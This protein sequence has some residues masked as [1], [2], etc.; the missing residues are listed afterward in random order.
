MNAFKQL[1]ETPIPE[2]NTNAILFEHNVTKAQALILK[3]DEENKL[4]SANFKTLPH[5]DTGVAHILEHCVLA[6]SKNYPVK[7]PFV[8]LLKTSLKTFLNAMTFP[9]KTLYPVSSKNTQDFYNLMDVYLDAVFNPLLNENTFK[10]EGWHY[11][12]SNKEDPIIY[13]GV[14]FNEMKG[15]QSNPNSIIEHSITKTLYPDTIYKHDS[16]GD[17]Q[18]IPQLTY[19]EF[20]DFHKTYYHP[21]NAKFVITGNI[22]VEEC[23]EKI[24]SYIKGYE[25]S[26]ITAEIETQQAFETPKEYTT[27]YGVSETDKD[28]AIAVVGWAM[29]VDISAIDYFGLQILSA[30]LLDSEAA[31]IKKA[32][33]ESNLGESVIVTGIDFELKQA[34]F[35]TGLKGIQAENIPEVRKIIIACLEKLSTKLDKDLILAA[36]NKVEF[37]HRE[38]PTSGYPRA[39]E[40]LRTILEIWLYEDAPLKGLLFEQPLNEIRSKIENNEPY[41]EELITKYFVNNNHRAYVSI[42]PNVNRAKERLEKETNVLK[43]VKNEMSEEQLT[44]LVKETGQFIEWQNTPDTPEDEAKIPQLSAKDLSNTL[45]EVKQKI[46]QLNNV[47]I[48]QNKVNTNGITYIDIAY[49]IEVLTEEELKNVGIIAAV[50]PKLGTTTYNFEQLALEIDKYTGGIYTSLITEQNVITNELI[51]KFV[52]SVKCLEANQNKALELVKDILMNTDFAQIERLQTLTKELKSDLSSGLINSGHAYALHVAFAQLDTSKYIKYITTGI[53]FY[54]FLKKNTHIQEDTLQQVLT[55]VINSKVLINTTTDKNIESIYNNLA[56]FSFADVTDTPQNTTEQKSITLENINTAY[57]SAA[58]VNYN[59]KAI[60]MPRGSLNG[61]LYAIEKFI[62]NDYL[63][64]KVRVQ[65]GAYGGMF[66]AN[67]PLNLLGFV[68][69]RDP[70]LLDTY[71]VYDELAEYMQNHIFSEQELEGYIV[72]GYGT[73][74]SYQTPYS[75]GF[76]E[77]MFY[78]KGISIEQRQKY[79]EELLETNPADFIMLAQQI[80][81]VTTEN[82][83]KCT[84][85]NKDAISEQMNEKWK[86]I[87]L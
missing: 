4:F 11:E 44:D 71:K 72:S 38:G 76:E 36:L 22:N 5:N 31:P 20:V 47:E 65:G 37:A 40:Y 80:E 28:K 15:A 9:D 2:L 10:Q 25:Y 33:T 29:P 6:G 41:F 68:S 30:M 34:M 67:I 24:E 19:Q 69:Y 27:D 21:S 42:L 78:L 73:L 46:T 58:E 1:W 26:P 75:Q 14:V 13:K 49:D 79:L 59:A 39:V 8:N 56:A 48:L 57:A 51:L 17:P 32:L 85:G 60:K 54:N 62:R 63:W 43:K 84:I 18:F 7:E 23:L 12:L 87:E 53:G 64:T 3:S 61:S 55:K 74:D 77:F 66:T 45:K 52:V 50:L 82:T 81:A 35:V 83:A 70:K 16:G 86:I